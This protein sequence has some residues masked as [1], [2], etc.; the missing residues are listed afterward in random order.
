MGLSA[1]GRSDQQRMGEFHTD[2]VQSV[3]SFGPARALARL[4]DA[5]D[6]RARGRTG[7]RRVVAA[8]DRQEPS[9][10][11]HGLRGLYLWLLLCLAARQP[12][13]D[14]VREYEPCL[15]GAPGST[16]ESTEGRCGSCGL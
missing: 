13:A 15:L 8:V 9:G 12:S 5:A 16:G 10:R 3:R 2:C 4:C 14:G 1:K 6:Q 11:L 7:G